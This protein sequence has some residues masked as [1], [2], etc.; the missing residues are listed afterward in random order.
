MI[1]KAVFGLLF[2]YRTVKM[3]AKQIQNGYKRLQFDD[4]F[5]IIVDFGETMWYHVLREKNG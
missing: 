5:V 3:I 2:C 1:T 4:S